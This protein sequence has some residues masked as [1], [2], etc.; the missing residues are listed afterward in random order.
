MSFFTK[1]IKNIS[2]ATKDRKLSLKQEII[3]AVRAQIKE[4][5][6]KALEYLEAQKSAKAKA[7]IEANRANREAGELVKVG[8][9][10]FTTN[11]KE[12]VVPIEERK[13]PDGSMTQWAITRDGL[14][15]KRLSTLEKQCAF[16]GTETTI[17]WN[18]EVSQ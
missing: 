9:I 14:F 8:S 11:G 3:E 5:P 13:N 10:S 4:N 17:E 1:N 15:P 6:M 2:V 18:N 7:H 12:R 16:H